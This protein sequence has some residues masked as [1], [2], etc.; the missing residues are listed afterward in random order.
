M[1]NVDAIEAAVGAKCQIQ[2]LKVKRSCKTRLMR[3]IRFDEA[4]LS[5]VPYRVDTKDGR[6]FKLLAAREANHHAIHSLLF[7][8]DVIASLDCAPQLIW[9]DEYNLLLDFV[10]GEIPE[11]NEPE[12]AAAFGRN[13]AEIYQLG[14]DTLPAATILRTAGKYIEDMVDTG[15]LEVSR[16]DDISAHLATRLPERL[17]TS[18]DYADVQPGNFRIKSNGNLSFIDIGGFQ[19][20]RLTGEGFFGHPGSKKLDQ[21]HFGAAYRNAGGPDDV[22]EFRDVIV[23]LSDLRRGAR[24]AVWADGIKFLQP[25]KARAF[26]TRARG[27]AESLQNFSRSSPSRPN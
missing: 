23:A 18:V 5:P 26:R 3:K 16:A 21:E 22:F 25:W 17:R 24:L 7:R 4:A 2:L 19:V 20:G 10:Q 12:C 6:T 27:I 8:C 13:L 9:H 1:I 15:L 11:L 14:V